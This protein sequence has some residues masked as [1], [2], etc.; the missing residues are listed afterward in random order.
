MTETP[1][2]RLY[3]SRNQRMIAGVC[4]GL[5]EYANLDPTVVRVLYVLLAI[6]TGGAALIAYPLMWVIVPEEPLPAGTWPPAPPAPPTTP[7][8]PMAA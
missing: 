4:G 6:V 3:R 5:A 7:T 1:V 2:R 8:P